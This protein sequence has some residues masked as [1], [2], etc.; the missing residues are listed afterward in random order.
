MD[1]ENKF[2][3]DRLRTENHPWEEAVNDLEVSDDK[4]KIALSEN[5]RMD[6]RV[7]PEREEIIVKETE[8]VPPDFKGD[9]LCRAWQSHFESNICSFSLTEAEGYN[10][11]LFNEKNRKNLILSNTPDFDQLIH[12]ASFNR[13]LKQLLACK[14]GGQPDI[15]R[16]KSMAIPG[17]SFED[18][19]SRA[20][21]FREK[22]NYLASEL[23]KGGNDVIKKMSGLLCD[24]FGSK[25]PP[26]WA[27]F[28]EDVTSFI[29]DEKWGDL[30]KALGLGHF[31]EGEWILIWVYEKGKVGPVYRPTMMESNTSQYHYPS[32]PS[33]SYGISMPL[34]A[35]LP[36]CR[37][38]LHRPLN[39]EDTVEAC[40]GRLCQIS[41]FEE[42]DYQH[43][44]MIHKLRGSHF[45]RLKLKFRE[46][47]DRNWFE[48]HN[49]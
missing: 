47:N 3:F 44:E 45:N 36:D 35:E 40:T 19:M 10:P 16:E 41:G 26:W 23:D 24:S 22:V 25:Q 6:Y 18:L 42:D 20:E 32:P 49:K 8:P 38:V 48:R 17:F 28:A 30:C 15:F 13:M 1:R 27:C 2:V 12:V 5:C 11:E 39:V 43:N 34:S 21:N 4:G 9:D 7:S 46:V 37:E 33:S 31:S 29:Q 14:F